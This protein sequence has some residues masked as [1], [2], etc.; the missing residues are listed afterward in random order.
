MSRTIRRKGYIPYW[1]THKFTSLGGWS[2]GWYYEPLE[3][4][5][6]AK[7]LSEWHRCKHQYRFPSKWLRSNLQKTYKAKARM[8][9]EQFKK[10]PDYEVIIPRKELLPWD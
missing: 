4:K 7:S 3:G 8:E 9:L 1:V 2:Y 10:N 6:L 5:A